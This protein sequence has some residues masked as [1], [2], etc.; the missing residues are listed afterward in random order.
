VP[1]I[2]T[3]RNDLAAN[4]GF[5]HWFLSTDLDAVTTGGWR[6]MGRMAES[7]SIASSE[8]RLAVE[9]EELGG[10]LLGDHAMGPT[11]TAGSATPVLSKINLAETRPGSTSFLSGSNL[12]AVGIG[13]EARLNITAT[14][15][16]VMLIPEWCDLAAMSASPSHADW[17][18]VVIIWRAAFVEQGAIS[19]THAAAATSSFKVSAVAASTPPGMAQELPASFRLYYRGNP[20][21]VATG[22]AMKAIADAMVFP[23]FSALLNDFAPADLI[24]EELDAW[25]GDPFTSGGMLYLGRLSGARSLTFATKV[26][27]ATSEAYGETP[28]G[29]VASGGSAGAELNVLEI[30]WDLYARVL[31]RTTKVVSGGSATIGLGAGQLTMAKVTASSLL[32]RP[33]SAADATKDI[34]IAHA[35]PEGPFEEPIQRA[36]R[37][38][39]VRFAGRFSTASQ[40]P[41]GGKVA[42]YGDAG[43]AGVPVT[44]NS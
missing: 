11:L 13:R 24:V 36:R 9:I 12:V 28:I 40:F 8:S 3:F 26:D 17:K 38:M 31:S 16:S 37:E 2:K 6:Y 19:A 30:D 18:H 33:I 34:L 41:S 44:Y 7:T 10:A 1:L 4:I 5:C 23:D 32:L 27:L 29:A 22:H 42:I 43:A 15:P 14:M 20:K 25:F 39:K 35:V 21:A